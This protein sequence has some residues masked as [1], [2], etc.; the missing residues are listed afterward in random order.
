MGVPIACRGVGAS[1]ARRR[2]ASRD[3][4][5]RGRPLCGLRRNRQGRRFCRLP[6]LH[7]QRSGARLQPRQPA[8][9]AHRVG[10]PAERGHLPQGAVWGA[11]LPVSRAG[12]AVWFIAVKSETCCKEVHLV[13]SRHPASRPR[14]LWTGPSGR[15]TTAARSS[16]SRLEICCLVRHHMAWSRNSCSEV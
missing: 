6:P 5:V 7:D 12:R 9:R 14:P 8:C 13:R 15:V 16:G 1:A 2:A 3:S 10:R 4:A 11:V